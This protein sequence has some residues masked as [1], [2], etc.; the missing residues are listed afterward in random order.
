MERL[1]KA[2]YG[3]TPITFERAMERALMEKTNPVR[4]KRMAF[5]LV[6]GMMIIA[7]ACTALAVGLQQSAQYSAIRAAREALHEKYGITSETLGIFIQ[8]IEKEDGQW[9]IRLTPSKYDH[10]TVGIYTVIVKADGSTEASWSNDGKPLTPNDGFDAEVWGQPQLEAA[11]ALDNAHIKRMQE[12]DWATKQE[13][14]LEERAEMDEALA[15]AGKLAWVVHVAPG[16][17]DIREE[18]AVT[19]AKDTL[20]KHYG[21]S[22]EHLEGYKIH[23]ELLKYQDESEKQ[24]RIYLHREEEIGEGVETFYVSF[25][26]TSGTEIRCRWGVDPD[27]R[28]LP[29]GDLTGYKEAVQEFVEEGAFEVASAADKADIAARIQAAGYGE[30]LPYE[31]YAAPEAGDLS[32]TDAVKLAQKA[33]RESFGFT[34]ETLGLFQA[35]SFLIL[36]DEERLW[37]IDYSPVRQEFFRWDVNEQLGTYH[38]LLCADG[39]DLV[40]SE[41]SLTAE[42]LD[43]IY[44]ETTWGQAPALHASLLPWAMELMEYDKQYLEVYIASDLPG[45]PLEESAALDQLFR[46]RGFPAERY[47]NTLPGEG[48]ITQEEA[49]VIAKETLRTDFGISEARIDNGMVYASFVMEGSEQNVWHFRIFPSENSGQEDYWVAVDAGTGEVLH[50]VNEGVGNG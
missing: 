37:A 17:D 1:S 27:H 48:D 25:A 19:L 29:E 3:T 8:H 18:E 32:E 16:P 43:E 26:A 15:E 42:W 28:T 39:G 36:K 34:E 33:M 46:D 35:D 40:G 41:W 4:T 50:A 49:L 31:I 24:Y 13:W 9:T 20:V 47:A 45:L 38:V 23:V 14:T 7:L 30:L 5:V 6:M 2:S 12:N 21:I 10:E 44:T 11:L 22:P